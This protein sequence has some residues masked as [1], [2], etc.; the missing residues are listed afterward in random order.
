MPIPNFSGC[1]LDCC[2]PSFGWLV[3]QIL[4][5]LFTAAL[6]YTG[7]FL[8]C[9]LSFSLFSVKETCTFH[10][11]LITF[12]GP[13]FVDLHWSLPVSHSEIISLH[14]PDGRETRTRR[15]LGLHI[16]FPSQATPAQGRRS[17][18]SDPRTPSQLTMQRKTNTACF[19]STSA[20]GEPNHSSS[21]PRELQRCSEFLPGAVLEAGNYHNAGYPPQASFLSRAIGE[22]W[23]SEGWKSFHW[24][25]RYLKQN[26]RILHPKAFSNSVKSWK[27]AH[28]N[29][30]PDFRPKQ[31]LKLAHPCLAGHRWVDEAL[32]AL[33][34]SSIIR[35]LKL[36]WS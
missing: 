10:S 9:S 15:D 5:I 8:L 26:W 19:W 21:N 7:R 20:P 22:G 24:S 17:G 34:K 36:P 30:K 3:E 28:T 32:V 4:T 35:K 27:V 33:W 23:K 13:G 6:L 25:N 16:T 14:V 18:E 29:I 1:K 2:L 11:F 12:C 31:T